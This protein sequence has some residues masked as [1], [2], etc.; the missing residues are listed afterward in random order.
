VRFSG[1]GCFSR[2]DRRLYRVNSVENSRFF[3]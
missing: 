2:D 3:A 1:R